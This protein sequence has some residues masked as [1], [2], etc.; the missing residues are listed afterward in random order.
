MEYMNRAPE[1]MNDPFAEAV[2]AEVSRFQ[3]IT[4][5]EDQEEWYSAVLDFILMYQSR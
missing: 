2:V 4:S 5:I 1:E 3:C